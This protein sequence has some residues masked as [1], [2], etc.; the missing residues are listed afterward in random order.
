MVSFSATK[1]PNLCSYFLFYLCSN[2][3]G[4]IFVALP[5]LWQVLLCHL[6]WGGGQNI[7]FMMWTLHKFI[8][9]HNG[10][11]SYVM[12]PLSFHA[13]HSCLPKWLL[14]QP[15]FPVVLC[16]GVRSRVVWGWYW[17]KRKPGIPGSKPRPTTET[18]SVL[19]H[20]IS[21]LCASVLSPGKKELPNLTQIKYCE[22]R[23]V[24]PRHLD[25]CC[26][27]REDQC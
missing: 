5:L 1:F 21:P 27:T 23:W 10:A 13:C 15:P 6:E 17:M 20:I 8:W 22:M 19:K 14:V 2:L 24:C 3:D 12:H 25:G 7:L 16:L 18:E 26:W 9:W 4:S 11:F